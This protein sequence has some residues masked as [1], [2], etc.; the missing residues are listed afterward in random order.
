MPH[1]VLLHGPP[2]IGRKSLG[3]WLA[4]VVLQA[5]NADWPEWLALQ[6]QSE[7][8]LCAPHPDLLLAQPAAGK[9]SIS[10]EGMR[11]LIEFLQLTSHARA[12][13]VSLIQPAQ[14]LT[15]N[16]ANSLL[17][18]LEEPPGDSLIILVSDMPSQL[19]ATVVSRC[20]RLRVAA[21]LREP[22]L[23]WLRGRNPG[24]DDWNP[25]LDIAGNAPLLALE[26]ARTGG[27]DQAAELEQDVLSLLRMEQTPIAVVRKWLK[28]GDPDVCL[29]W[30]YCR[31]SR[32]I[33]RQLLKQER[34][35]GS[36][37]GNAH[38][39]NPGGTLNINTAFEYLR[40]LQEYR[41]IGGRGTGLNAELNLASLLM[42]WY[43]GFS[44]P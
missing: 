25:L 38:L 27:A 2:G 31:V 20:Y 43:G 1:A 21:P 11:E 33:E 42:W 29:R 3:L 36:I 12:T 39:Q 37:P 24:I 32:G 18:T 23:Q 44:A 35:C 6:Q 34:D 7:E 22:A 5:T 4:S 14:A 28:R 41:R 9:R 40:E 8:E 17:K 15:H 13:K 16:A 30:L 10:I 26:L 19:P